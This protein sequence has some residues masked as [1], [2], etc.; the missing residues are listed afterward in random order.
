MAGENAVKVW[1]SHRDMAA[2]ELAK[3]A[4]ISA[5]YLSESKSGKK[6]GSPFA[7]RKIADAPSVDLD[8]LG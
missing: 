3:K 2:R 7:V 5:P 8:D 4:G 6:D 1:R